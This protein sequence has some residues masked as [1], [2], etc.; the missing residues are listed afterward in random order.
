MNGKDIVNEGPL[1]NP[2]PNNYDHL[3]KLV[4]NWILSLARV[5]KA[6]YRFGDVFTFVNYTVKEDIISTYSGIFNMAPPGNP[7]LNPSYLAKLQETC[8]Q[9]GDRDP[10][11]DLDLGSP[12]IFDNSYFVN[13]QINVGLLIT[14]QDLYSTSGSPTTVDLVNNYSRNL[15]MFFDQFVRSMIK[16]GN[17]NPLTRNNG[18]IRLN[19]RRVNNPN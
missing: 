6:L 7:G 12:R 16:M 4:Y 3:S 19:C 17:I 1:I 14:D 2:C 13:L 10:E 5:A 8:P 9:N 11:T 15:S 18:E